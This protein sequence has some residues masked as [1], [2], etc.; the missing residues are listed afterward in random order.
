MCWLFLEVKF[1]LYIGRP[2]HFQ[3]WAL[4]R[5][6]HMLTTHISA[7]IHSPLLTLKRAFPGSPN[8]VSVFSLLSPNSQS[9]VCWDVLQLSHLIS[10]FPSSRPHHKSQHM[11]PNMVTSHNAF[12]NQTGLCLSVEQQWANSSASGSHPL[13]SPHGPESFPLK[14]E[15]IRPSET[16][17]HSPTTRTRSNN[18][19]PR[20]INHHVNLK[21][22]KK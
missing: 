15:A 13:H 17:V 6:V 9:Y 10:I 5:A 21:N 1:N 4:K 12:R 7:P 18:G 2:A 8:I 22:Y 14:M 3:T 16:A 20:L 11:K 19:G